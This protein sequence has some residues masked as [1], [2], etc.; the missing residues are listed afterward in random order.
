MERT[1]V[2]QA[3]FQTC[4]SWGWGLFPETPTENK[5]FLLRASAGR[6]VAGS[7]GPLKTGL[8]HR[9]AGRQGRSSPVQLLP[10][11][12]GRP[13][14]GAEQAV[15]MAATGLIELVPRGVCAPAHAS[16]SARAGQLA[17]PTPSAPPPGVAEV[18]EE[19][20]SSGAS[21]TRL[22]PGG[23]CASGSGSAGSEG[24][25]RRRGPSVLTPGCAWLVSLPGSVRDGA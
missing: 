17:P 18:A 14:R 22:R 21:P 9:L 19:P 11:G 20:P 4:T 12:P 16:I 15:Q 10:A 3:C 5:L 13:S 25:P 2:G 23:V 7:P 24:T 1:D 6:G 8:L